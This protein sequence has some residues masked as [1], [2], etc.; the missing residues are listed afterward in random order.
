MLAFSAE[1]AV[2]AGYRALPQ[3]SR[4]CWA[5]AAVSGL[6][7]AAP[8]F[9]SQQHSRWYSIPGQR[10]SGSKWRYEV[11]NVVKLMVHRVEIGYYNIATGVT[12]NTARPV[13]P[14]LF[15]EAL[16]HLQKKV[17]FLQVCLPERD[18]RMWVADMDMPKIDFQV[19]KD[20]SLLDVV[21]STT[22]GAF[23]LA[24]GPLWC[25]RLVVCPPEE[26]CKLPQ[27]KD[28]FPHQYHF[29]VHCH[30]ATSD[31]R[32]AINMY[33]VFSTLLDNLLDGAQV[34]EK[35]IGELRD[36][37]EDRAIEAK[38]KETLEKD[39]QKLKVLLEEVSKR[40]TRVPLITE[41]FGEP[42]EPYPDTISLPTEVLDYELLQVFIAKCKAH[43]VTVNSGFGGVLNAALV[44]LVRE[45]GMVQ[46]SYVISSCHSVD[47]RRYMNDVKS[48]VWGYHACNMVHTMETPC[49]VRKSF[50]KY[51]VDYDSKFHSHLNMKGPLQDRMLDHMV[52]ATMPDRKQKVI[53]DFFIVSL[54]SPQIESF[55]SGKHIQLSD[56][57][58]YSPLTKTDF[59]MVNAI[60]SFPD[61]VLFQ[62]YMSSGFITKENAEKFVD[63]VIGMFYD[64]SKTMD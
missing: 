55:G 23:N 36:R 46:D 28:A 8:A 27:V 61:R 56:F 41:A 16:M 58:S 57:C 6:R 42:Q 39:P 63:K 54:H 44:E 59:G 24:E 50:W 5:A 49:N 30:H 48:L 26:P 32:S 34:D 2:Q 35:P 15:E 40:K 62:P 10:C 4:D 25:A 53:Y 43:K 37:N 14:D 52:L 3:W 22:K 45:A 60:V 64:I 17:E 31:S 38:M 12:L 20:G 11:D 1:M 19:L 18:G 51:V 21:K 9:W 13:T 29:A 7:W 47:T 33:Q